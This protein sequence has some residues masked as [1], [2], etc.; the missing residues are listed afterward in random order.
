MIDISQWRASIGLW[1]Y[2]ICD[3][4]IDKSLPALCRKGT[5]A[6]K[7]SSN[8]KHSQTNR[9]STAVEQ[10]S[11]NEIPQSRA[12]RRNRYSNSEIPVTSTNVHKPVALSNSQTQVTGCTDC[13]TP[14]LFSISQ[15]Q[16]ESTDRQR[17]L[18]SLSNGQTQVPSIDGHKPVVLSNGQIPLA[19]TNGQTP[20]ASTNGQ[21][22]VILFIGQTS[23]NH[24]TQV[25]SSNVQKLVVSTY[26]LV[27]SNGQT[28]V[29]SNNGQ[30]HVALYNCQN[31][32][33]STDGQKLVVLSNSSTANTTMRYAD[34]CGRV[35]I[36]SLAVFLFRLLLILSG[37]IEL[38]PGPKTGNNTLY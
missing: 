10:I 7:Q 22:P 29:S 33:Q 28:P 30:K 5:R 24:Q 18:V 14:V 19:S 25:P 12:N 34:W 11:S 38:N 9:N 6:K 8:E 13:Q 31:P 36:I 16:V 3:N 26:S 35:Q 27:L 23:T 21:R 32:V 2:Q 4:V 15:K 17:Q 37:D 20:L 1:Y